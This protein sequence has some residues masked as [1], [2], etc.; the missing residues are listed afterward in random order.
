MVELKPFNLK[1]AELHYKWNNDEELNYFDSDFPL[2]PESF[3][4]FIS[5]IVLV[6]DENNNTSKL[7][8]IHESN[9]NTLI[10]IVD[11]HNIDHHNRHCHVECSIGEREYRHKGY[12]TAALQK[13]LKYC[14][15]DLNMQKVIA[16][17]FDFNKK[18]ANILKKTGFRH[19]GTL[20]RHAKKNGS[21]CN[22]LIFGLLEEEFK[23]TGKQ[24]VA[25]GA[26]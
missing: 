16:T 3:D 18:W 7:L 24:K 2:T 12:G 19:E 21:Y 15:D 5:R 22:K 4:S 13:A 25:V 23:Q 1:N 6:T 14:F 8:E 9:L 17:S 10:G 20:R 26:E 11:I